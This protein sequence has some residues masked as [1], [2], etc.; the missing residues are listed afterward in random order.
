M[1]SQR[2]QRV[3]VTLLLITI[4]LRQGPSQIPGENQRPFSL[5]CS[6]MRELVTYK[7][8]RI[9]AHCAHPTSATQA[10]I[11]GPTTWN[12]FLRTTQMAAALALLELG[13]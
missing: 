12:F 11:L 7:G 3:V 2:R 5:V 8:S 13:P 10:D 9:T 6:E 4:R 1:C